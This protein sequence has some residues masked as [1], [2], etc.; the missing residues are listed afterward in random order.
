[1]LN[2]PELSKKTTMSA[3]NVIKLFKLCVKMTYF[4]FNG[5]LH[6]QVDGLAI[7]ASSSGFAA[8]LFMERLE[9]KA[10][11][12][13]I[14]PPKLW[15]RYV[16][17]TFSKLKKMHVES[18]LEHLNKQHPR[19]EFTT[20]N[21]EDDR[22]AFL[23]TLVHVLPSG[24]TK[25]TIYRKA[26]HTDQYLDFQSNHHIKQK[27]GIINTFKHRI[28]ELVTEEED[29]AK[30]LKHVKKALKRCGHPNWS[31]NRRKRQEDREKVE[32]RGK[33]VIPYVRG[34]SERLARVYKKYDIETIHKP[35]RTIRSIL[36]NKM[37]DKVHE[38]D[39]T[40]AV[41]YN[42][43]KK[44]PRNDYVGETDR[45]LR[46]RLYEHRIIDHNRATRSA[47]LNEEPKENEERRTRTRSRSTRERT[48]ID[49]RVMHEGTD[50]QLTVGNTEFSAHVASD[51]HTK[52]DLQYTVLCTDDNWYR[53]G[54]KEAI[55]IHKIQPTLN[56]DEG[57]HHLSPIYSKL[58][59]SSVVLKTPRTRATD[60]S[61]ATNF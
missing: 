56:Q 5:K 20:E 23:D 6:I 11:T 22:I 16:D 4:V 27:I 33:V 42:Q 17:D 39:R 50:Q 52:S 1:M 40:G 14:E 10:I 12:T 49:Y 31:L 48:R 8:D 35:T 21:L 15:K 54:I 44:H 53:R 47:S 43:C 58:I 32:R 29:K 34:L 51:T 13:F 38:L 60:G 28:E 26:T 37:K 2:D 9:T 7:G 61:E 18:F 41:Y 3:A 24:T 46:E 36:C 30:E 45:V 19:I 55:A 57:R 25:I 59:R